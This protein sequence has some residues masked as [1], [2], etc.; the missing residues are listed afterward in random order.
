[1]EEF[2][3]LDVGYDQQLGGGGECSVHSYDVNRVLNKCMN[4]AKRRQ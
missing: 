1:M 2:F 3:E 4:A